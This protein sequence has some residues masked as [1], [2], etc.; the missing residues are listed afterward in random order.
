MIGDANVVRSNPTK[1]LDA[2]LTLANGKIIQTSVLQ[3]L[4]ADAHALYGGVHV[5]RHVNFRNDLDVQFGSPSQDVAVVG[6][7]IV[8]T[9]GI[10][11]I[12]RCGAQVRQKAG[13]LTWIMTTS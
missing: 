11:G 2:P 13:V 9:L 10:S 7:R 12:V 8:P 1:P 6:N 5:T 3:P 4:G